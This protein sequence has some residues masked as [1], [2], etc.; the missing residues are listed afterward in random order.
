M[1]IKKLVIRNQKEEKNIREINF[2][3]GVNLI[4]DISEI[5]NQQDTGN[6]V[7]KT[8]VLRLIN[9]CLGAKAD[10][11]YKNAE[12]SKTI[13]SKVKNFLIDNEIV[14]I[15]TLCTDFN[16]TKTDVVIKRNFLADKK[17]KICSIDDCEYSNVENF[18][19]ELKSIFY[20][21]I[22]NKPSFRQLIDKHL[23]FDYSNERI[24]NYLHFGTSD[25]EYEQIY[26]FLYNLNKASELSTSK[27]SEI[28]KFKEY[29][30]IKKKLFKDKTSSL[31][32]QELLLLDTNVEKLEQEKLNFNVSNQ[33]KKELQEIDNIN[34]YI[35]RLME[36]YSLL[37][38][39]L[40][41]YEQNI[42]AIEADKCEFEVK[43]IEA[44]YNEAEIYLPK[45]NKTLE[46]AI[47]F[48]NKL[49]ANKVNFIKSDIPNLKQQINNL[50]QQ[51]DTNVERKKTLE[52]EQKTHGS[53][54]QYENLISNLKPYY[55]QKGKLSNELEKILEYE[56]LLNTCDAKITAINK[57]IEKYDEDLQRNLCVFNKYFSEYSINF[58][59]ESY[60][61]STSK[62]EKN[63][64]YKFEL[65]NLNSNI[66][67][68]KKKGLM[69]AYDLAYLSFAN[70]LKLKRPMFVLHD[71]IEDIHS[72]QLESLMNLVNSDNFVG[73]Y[74]VSV[75]SGKFKEENLNKLLEENK[76]I[77]LSP[78]EKLFK[79][80]TLTE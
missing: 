14:I 43:D 39:R 10:E 21:S 59:N 45:I 4:V 5:I 75:L 77:E 47:N 65:S 17:R 71:R 79:I 41:I 25:K 9:Y 19:K 29:E 56:K 44:L 2:K 76:I 13:N 46:E 24:I 54:A 78:H 42:L 12:S 7:G 51:I 74:I 11:I 33:Y 36:E 70:E 22:S 52:K 50:K 18:K 32:E 35:N 61:I 49:M 69:S 6:D 66:G 63:K 16:D 58:Y 27:G 1:F 28:D 20:N 40:K 73:Q 67:A 37:K 31:I 30:N 34:D 55:E 64:C 57:E 60:L 8:T 38:T 26:F 15:L 3:L 68:G 72:N 62:S 53:L 80:E 23:R 48:H